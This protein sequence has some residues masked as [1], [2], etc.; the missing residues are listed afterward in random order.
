M[1]NWNP[2]KTARNV[3][4]KSQKNHRQIKKITKTKSPNCYL[5]PWSIWDQLKSI[6]KDCSGKIGCARKTQIQESEGEKIQVQLNFSC[7]PYFVFLR[8]CHGYLVFFI[9]FSASW[10]SSDSNRVLCLLFVRCL[11]SLLWTT[12]VINWGE[13]KWSDCNENLCKRVRFYPTY[14]QSLLITEGP[15]IDRVILPNVKQVNNWRRP[16][17][18]PCQINPKTD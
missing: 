1:T 11:G 7:F 9:S 10:G 15:L 14:P 2:F 13:F 5:L 8:V 17:I 4:N 3:T 6:S 12:I 16:R 18:P